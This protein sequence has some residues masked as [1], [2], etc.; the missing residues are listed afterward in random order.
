MDVVNVRPDGLHGHDFNVC[1]LQ[2]NNVVDHGPYFLGK[3]LT[4]VCGRLCT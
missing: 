3:L 1:I 4:I 2:F